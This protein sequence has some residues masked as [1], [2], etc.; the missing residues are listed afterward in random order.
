IDSG[1]IPLPKSGN[2]ERIRENVNIFDFR[3]TAE[4]LAQ[5]DALNWDRRLGPDPDDYDDD[6]TVAMDV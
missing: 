6:A 3:L 4:D 1:L 5:I 2:P